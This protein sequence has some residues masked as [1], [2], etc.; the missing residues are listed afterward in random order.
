MMEVREKVSEH[1]IHPAPAPVSGKKSPQS[2]CA[3]PR[4]TVRLNAVLEGG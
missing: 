3:L 4:Q 2:L 1:T